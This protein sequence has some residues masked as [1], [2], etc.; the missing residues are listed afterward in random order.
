[1]SNENAAE[2]VVIA[3]LEVEN[4]KRIRCARVDPGANEMVVVG[5]ENESGKTSLLDAIA[6]A[7]GGA[8][9]CPQEPLRRGQKKGRASVTL[10]NGLVV[11]R[12]FTKSG[13]SLVVTDPTGPVKSPQAVLDKLVG[14]LTF[15]PL[16]FSR[17]KP[18]DQAAT[19]RTLAKLDTSDLDAARQAAYEERT[20]VNREAKAAEARARSMPVHD[21]APEKEESVAAL[22]EERNRLEARN[23]E[24]TALQAKA[25]VAKRELEDCRQGRDAKAERIREYEQMLAKLR[26]ELE[27]LDAEM[28]AASERVADIEARVRGFEWADTSAVDSRIANAESV[29]RKVRENQAAR[30]ASAELAAKEGESAALTRK[31]EELDAERRERIASADLPIEGLSLDEQGDVR[32][33]ETLFSE[34]SAAQKLRV[35][36]SMGIAA[37]PALNIMLIRDGSLLDRANMDI[38]AGIAKRAKAQVWIERVGAGPETSVVLED[39]QVKGREEQQ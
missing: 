3:A 20:A 36:V 33:K 7:V 19:L 1:M 31:I 28:D 29:N 15:D 24:G 34:C 11:E 27:D 25:S 16:A 5:G 22:I 21:D 6:G 30:Q 32:Y 38:I 17:A 12:R 9:L 8:K 10:T 14:E 26:N 23:A 39:G 13:S 4:V 35:S 18:S 37:N 2:K